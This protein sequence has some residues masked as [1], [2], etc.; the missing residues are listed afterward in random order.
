MQCGRQKKTLDDLKKTVLTLYDLKFSYDQM[1]F[2]GVQPVYGKIGNKR[3]LCSGKSGSQSLWLPIYLSKGLKVFHPEGQSDTVKKVKSA[4][5]AQKSLA[6]HGI[7]PKPFEL[8]NVTVYFKLFLDHVPSWRWYGVWGERVIC[9]CYSAVS[10]LESLGVTPRRGFVD[11][12]LIHRDFD[13]LSLKEYAL[14]AWFFGVD[15]THKIEVLVEEFKQKI[16]D[17]QQR[18]MDLLTWSNILVDMEGNFKVIDFDLC[19]DM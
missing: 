19:Y 10:F 13:A 4:Y 16:P 12:L 18:Y 3:F 9:T 14:L 7:A 15:V 2:R 5:E 17:D 1:F 8:C 6:E 11:A